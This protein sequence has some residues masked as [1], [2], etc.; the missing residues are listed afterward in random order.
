MTPKRAAITVDTFD[1]Y[2]GHV[3]TEE[4]VKWL[5]DMIVRAG[6]TRVYWYD[7]VAHTGLFRE[8]GIH[9]EVVETLKRLPNHTE[10][11]ARQARE[12][13]LEFFI[14]YKP[15]E[16]G[17]PVTFV[18]GSQD[19]KKYGK[20]QRIGGRAGWATDW[21]ADH[22]HLRVKRRMD[23]VPDDIHQ[24]VIDRVEIDKN[25][26]TPSGLRK[27]DIRVYVSRDNATYQEY[28]GEWS[29]TEETVDTLVLDYFG[30]QLNTETNQ[31]RRITID[32]LG[33]GPEWP[34]CVITAGEKADRFRFIPMSMCKVY[35]DKGR[36]L[37]VTFATDNADRKATLC[38]AT[39]ERD[40]RKYG[41]EFD[42]MGRA[43]GG[44]GT[45][46]D[47]SFCALKL[48]IARGVNE[49]LSGA[50]CEGYDAVRRHWKDRVRRLLSF[51]PDGIQ[52]RIANHCNDTQDPFAYGFNEPIL[53][54][55]QEREGSDV[56]AYDP[57]KI[58]KIRGEFFTQFL[59]EASEEIRAAGKTV[60]A[61]VIAPY[62]GGNIRA[63]ANRSFTGVWPNW[64]IWVRDL[65]DAILFRDFLA[66]NYNP[67]FDRVIKPFAR[68][69]G[70]EVWVPA[71][72]SMSG[73]NVHDTYLK[74]VEA[75]DDVTG[76][77][78]YESWPNYEEKR[79]R[80]EFKPKWAG[81][82]KRFMER[83]R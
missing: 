52:I 67:E 5:L 4:K 75:D 22:Q 49:H 72:F 78:F 18:P 35:D 38:D 6:F 71:Y 59:S 47:R 32:G 46:F 80:F 24:R 73:C 81:I 74:A 77:V 54:R 25:D 45:Y 40:F 33:I 57:V 65:V 39:A 11:A 17:M 64:E 2:I 16:E 21:L 41:F 19:D 61:Q 66:H 12:L 31:T 34:Y 60:Q 82:I 20:V 58:M 1:D 43:M 28:D 14:T 10:V 44:Y 69:L 68:S 48:G 23:D 36:R 56:V 3:F 51:D 70:R 42:E 13:G 7:Y 30:R 50:P 76:V 53:E 79:G 26:N 15:Y 55:Y 62:A 29:F 83:N 8:C 37:P 9:P 63:L 27:E